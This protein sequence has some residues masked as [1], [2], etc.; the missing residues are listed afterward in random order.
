MAARAVRRAIQRI[1]ESRQN[2]T[3]CDRTLRERCCPKAGP[4]RPSG[5]FAVSTGLELLPV[6]L[7]SS[8]LGRGEVRTGCAPRKGRQ[9][10]RLRSR[11]LTSTKPP[12]LPARCLMINA[13][14]WMK[15]CP[16][17]Q[18]ELVAWHRVARRIAASCA[19]WTNPP[20]GP[21]LVPALQ[22]PRGPGVRA[23]RSCGVEFGKPGRRPRG[24]RSRAG[25]SR[26]RLPCCRKPISRAARPEA[27][28]ISVR[29]GS[30]AR[31]AAEKPR[32]STFFPGLR[33]IE[34]AVRPA[35]QSVRHPVDNPDQTA[36]RSAGRLV[37]ARPIPRSQPLFTPVMC[38]GHR[39]ERDASSHAPAPSLPHVALV[40]D[41]PTLIRISAPRNAQV[42]RPQRRVRS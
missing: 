22:A 16:T 42:R 20:F 32:P 1:P 35:A 9:R 30:P 19:S 25:S 29:A 31:Q 5:K 33:A 7:R 26:I 13:G 18:F 2:V 36:P 3:A 4:S 8:R 24:R 40:D 37:R 11:T 23:V 14:R 38:I 6:I 10:R 27:Q 28:P 34:T 17:V 41:S 12:A 21:A 39:R 15:A